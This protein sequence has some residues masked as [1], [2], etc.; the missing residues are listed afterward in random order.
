VEKVGRSTISAA[1]P[2]STAAPIT[3]ARMPIMCMIRSAASSLARYCLDSAAAP[4]WDAEAKT[5]HASCG[6]LLRR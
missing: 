5:Y 4:S 6:R 3:P 1:M 2:I